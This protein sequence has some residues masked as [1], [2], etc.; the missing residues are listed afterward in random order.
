LSPRSREV[1]VAHFLSGESCADI[2]RR[3][4][5]TEQTIS[6]WVRQALQEMRQHQSGKKHELGNK[7]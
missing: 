2:G 7:V 3:H 1:L 4:R 6:S 5:R